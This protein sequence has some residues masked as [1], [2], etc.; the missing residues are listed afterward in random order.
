MDCDSGCFLSV[1]FVELP[2]AHCSVAVIA[3]QTR[4]QE[5]LI[6]LLLATQIF[7]C[8]AFEPLKDRPVPNCFAVV[9]ESSDEFGLGLQARVGLRVVAMLPRHEGVESGAHIPVKHTGL[10]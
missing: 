4:I 3:S 7:E 9:S 6:L 2:V 1:D 10:S 8:D 5:L